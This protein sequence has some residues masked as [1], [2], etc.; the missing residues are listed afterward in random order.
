MKKFSISERFNA[1]QK[2]LLSFGVALVILL[3]VVVF[4]V[5]P[6]LE[7]AILA[8]K[9]GNAL[10]EKLLSYER[11]FQIKNVQLLEQQQKEKLAY[12]Q[13]RL[14]ENLKQEDLMEEI[15][16]EGKQLQIKIMNLK[17][18]SV[19]KSK[20]LSLFIQC[21]GNY[22]SLVKFLSAVEQEGSFKNL[23]DVV[24]KGDERDGDLELVA[25]VTAYKN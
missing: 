23:H 25:V 17:Q 8:E 24:V 15:Y 16:L 18:L 6:L 10:A 11:Y 13:E 21:R 12:L 9:K 5:T 20:E 22:K 7:E 19:S 14:P 4:G 1:E 2:S 3:A